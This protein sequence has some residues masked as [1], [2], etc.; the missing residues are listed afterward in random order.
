MIDQRLI[1]LVDG[2]PEIARDYAA[3]PAEIDPE[4]RDPARVAA[5]IEIVTPPLRSVEED[6]IRFQAARLLCSWGYD[7]GFER[8]CE[9]IYDDK[10]MQ[11]QFAMQHRLRVYNQ[12][13]E[14]ALRSLVD[15]N[16][17]LSDAGNRDVARK[18][19][20]KPISYILKKAETEKFEVRELEGLVEGI[21]YKGYHKP[22]YIEYHQ[23][24]RDY[25]SSII[26]DPDT[27]HWKILDGLKMVERFDP[28]FVK[29]L[30]ESDS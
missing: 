15:Y 5:L 9:Y 1:E 28:D 25:I 19:I 13:Y 20:Q 17:R 23:P 21:D 6:Y 2:I 7:L 22:E 4:H 18:R 10:L 12:S 24:L 8:L 14:F 11:N 16:A 3:E 27:H 29:S 26:I 30:L